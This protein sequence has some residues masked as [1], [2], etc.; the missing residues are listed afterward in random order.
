MGAIHPSP[1]LDHL[2][3]FT[4]I[5]EREAYRTAG[6]VSEVSARIATLLKARDRATASTAAAMIN[7][8]DS[9][10]STMDG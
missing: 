2:V 9:R 7:A 4:L 3:A 8:S 1:V 6:G 10:G 5:N